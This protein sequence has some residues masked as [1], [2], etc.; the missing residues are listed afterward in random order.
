MSVAGISSGEAMNII[1]L[2]LTLGLFLVMLAQGLR[3]NGDQL[4]AFRRQPSTLARA[5]V[6]VDV[7]VPLV[8]VAVVGIFHPS[9]PIAICLALMASS[10]MAALGLS[11]VVQ[12]PRLRPVWAAVYFILLAAAVVTTPVTL[13]LL[14]RAFRFESDVSSVAIAEKVFWTV[15]FPVV[16]GSLFLRWKPSVAGRAAAPLEKAGML[17]VAIGF[18]IIVAASWRALAGFGLR[19]Y[20]A[21]A[22]FVI[23]CLTFGHL[24]GGEDPEARH[25]LAIESATRNPGLVLLIAQTSFPHAPVAAVLVPYLVTFVVVTSGYKMLKGQP[26]GGARHARLR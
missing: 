20:V 15:F 1:K 26:G 7:L 23:L 6:A 19:G 5:F 3:L 18:V 21:V 4:L 11:H 14:E 9:K 25:L 22:V 8:A 24:L 10:P 17:L 16:A 2:L 12:N 13:S